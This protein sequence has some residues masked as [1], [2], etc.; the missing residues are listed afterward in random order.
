MNRM[1]KVTLLFVSFIFCFSQP[2]V[3]AEMAY[4]D[5]QLPGTLFPR[6]SYVQN[7]LVNEEPRSP[8]FLSF[9][10][11]TQDDRYTV[12]GLVNLKQCLHEVNVIQKLNAEESTGGGIA[13]G[14]VDSIKDTG[15][16][17]KNLFFHPV[18][19]VKGI[20]KGV[21]KLGD[22][23][24]DTFRDK[25][26]GEKTSMG[27]SFLGS[28]KRE[29]AKQLGVDV[30]SRNQDLQEH[31]DK[32][33]KARLGG[34]GAVAVATFFV[35]VGL[36]ASAVM[37]VSN[38]NHAADE[39]V[40]DSDRGDLYKIN[41]KALLVLGFSEDH[42]VRFLNHS[43]YTPREL[44]Y[45]RFY[46]EGLRNISGY[47]DLFD[48]AVSAAP[49]LPADKLLHEIQIAADS[50]QTAPD[51]VR[52]SLIPEGIVLERKNSVA[53]ITAYDYLDHSAFGKK[54]ADL[55][56]SLKSKLGKNSAEIWNG[57]VVTPR[58]GGMLIHQG[59]S[60]RRMCL[61]NNKAAANEPV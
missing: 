59:I 41:Q 5:L 61:F 28:I 35:P 39:L 52:L 23:V 31:L 2:L 21:G 56:S 32:M 3:F 1:K 17:L 44:T 11:Q 14:A 15:R 8:G 4:K 47:R 50:I 29:L 16:G 36:V 34:R 53:L 57:G 9:S 30:Y 27:E 26:E 60:L 49:G 43:Y 24:G 48:A 45:L 20:G 22:K 54:I 33:A 13:D 38:I 6:S 40:N 55:V 37:T 42:V 46:L 19:S 12:L 10:I 7:I 51:A 58:Y 25:E 18:D